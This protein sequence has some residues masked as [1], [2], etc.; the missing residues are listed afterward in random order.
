MPDLPQYNIHVFANDD[1][2]PPEAEELFQTEL[3]DSREPLPEDRADRDQWQ[4]RLICALTENGHVLD[5][6]HFDMGPRNFG[7]L[8]H[9]RITYLEHCFVRPEYRR[10]GV[11]T[12][13]LQRAIEVAREEGCQIM[14]CNASWDSPQD[15]E[16]ARRFGGIGCLVRTGWAAQEEPVVQPGSPAAFIGDSITDAV[17]WILN[18]ETH[19]YQQLAWDLDACAAAQHPSP[20]EDARDVG[21]YSGS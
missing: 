8:G 17:D 7:P 20:M 5:G 16:A 4:F 11:G 13:L 3:A 12:R 1:Q 9:E 21:R 6:V 15:V 19:D 14:R 18:R 2:L 10:H